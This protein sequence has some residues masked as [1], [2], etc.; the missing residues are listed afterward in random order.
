MSDKDK[1][2]YD[3]KEKL[4]TTKDIVKKC[5][6][7]KKQCRNS[8][9]FLLWYFWRYQQDLDLNSYSDFSDAISAS[10]ITRCRREIQN[11][12]NELLPTKQEVI[13]KRSI[14]EDAVRDYYSDSRAEEILG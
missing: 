5:M 2:I 14:K 11:D 6:R 9:S 7:K 4:A 3:T 1:V 8:D 10:T 12:D 13:R